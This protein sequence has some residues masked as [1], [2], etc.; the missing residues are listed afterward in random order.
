MDETELSQ[1]LTKHGVDISAFGQGEA[2]KVSDL[3]A[4]IHNEEAALV[5]RDGRLLRAC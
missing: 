1:L 4:E 5:E 2:K 3:L